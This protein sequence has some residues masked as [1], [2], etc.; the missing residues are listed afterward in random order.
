MLLENPPFK[1][2]QYQIS[3]QPSGHRYSRTHAVIA[4]LQLQQQTHYHQAQRLLLVLFRVLFS[5]DETCR[6]VPTSQDLV[7]GR[8]LTQILW[9][10]CQRV[11]Y[12]FHALW[13]R[14]VVE[15]HYHCLLD[16][17]IIRALRAYVKPF[18]LYWES[19]VYSIQC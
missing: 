12:L 6:A 4:A 7:G 11:F 2:S 19:L 3:P 9:D 17:F 14:E 5:W 16:C 10:F 18:L 13:I 15:L 1:L 8:G